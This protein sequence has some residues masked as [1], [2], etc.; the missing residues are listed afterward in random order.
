MNSIALAYESVLERVY[1]LVIEIVQVIVLSDPS[2][3]RK[4]EE[5][6]L[7]LVER[8]DFLYP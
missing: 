1:Q 7:E 2:F 4:V 6:S 5:G 3:I 8:L